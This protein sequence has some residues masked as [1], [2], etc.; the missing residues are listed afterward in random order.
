MQWT[1]DVYA[2]F[3]KAE[4]WLPISGNL[5]ECNVEFQE[6]SKASMLHFVRKMIWL[7]KDLPALLNGSYS[8]FTDEVPDDCFGYI[9]ENPDHKLAVY[10][11]FS[12]KTMMIKA[13][14]DKLPARLIISTDLNRD[15]EKVSGDSITLSSYEGCIYEY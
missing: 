6:L 8:A 5:V 15:E 14:K 7:R 10:L 4:P 2:G 1:A 9:R 3:S 13:V 12:D 11:N